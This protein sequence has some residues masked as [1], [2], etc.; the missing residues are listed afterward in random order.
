[1]ILDCRGRV[2]A[3]SNK[4][5]TI[6]AEPRAIKD[7]EAV[8]TKL[9]PIVR[10]GAREIYEIITESRNPGFAKIKEEIGRAHV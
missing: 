5:Q 2:L 10:M 3:A 4:V 1:M 6:F 9:A 8:S 7:A